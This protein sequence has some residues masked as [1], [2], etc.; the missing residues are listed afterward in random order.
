MREVAE[1]VFGNETD[2]DDGNGMFDLD[3]LASNPVA[4]CP[5]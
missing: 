1:L 5:A 3:P 4:S 2:L